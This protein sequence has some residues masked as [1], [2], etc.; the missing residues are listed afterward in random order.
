MIKIIVAGALGRMGTSIINVI[1]ETEGVFLAGA[2]EMPDHPAIG[3]DLS[4]FLNFGRKGVR[5]TSIF[6][7]GDGVVY[8]HLGQILSKPELGVITD[9]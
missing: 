4:E 1:K 5:I 6:T 3:K 9:L 7:R 8:S 2:L